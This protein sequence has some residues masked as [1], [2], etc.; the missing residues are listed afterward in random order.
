MSKYKDLVTEEARVPKIDKERLGGWSSV[1]EAYREMR[2]DVSYG[3]FR[4]R[5]LNGK[6]VVEAG[7]MPR[8]PRGRPVKG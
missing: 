1:A 6:S 4:S 8:S 5:I 2:P 3:A 7:T